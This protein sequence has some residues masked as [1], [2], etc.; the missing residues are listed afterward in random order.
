MGADPGSSLPG[1]YA[2]SMGKSFPMFLNNL[3]PPSSGP[4]HHEDGGITILLNGG[5]CSPGD[6]AFTSELSQSSDKAVPLQAQRV[7]GS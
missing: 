2:V 5:N 6:T 1:C 7:P 3:V 4:L